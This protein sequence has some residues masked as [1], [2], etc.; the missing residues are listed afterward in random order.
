MNTAP[1]P[2]GEAL[3][4]AILTHPD[5]DTP[6]LAYADHIEEMGY[7][8]RAEFIRAQCRLAAMNPWDEGYTATDV[9]CR[10]LL[11]EHPEWTDAVVRYHP[12]L[13]RQFGS[14]R[15]RGAHGVFVRGFPGVVGATAEWFAHHH[16]SLF[17]RVPVRGVGFH[18]ETAAE[19]DAL[20]GCPG[21]ERLASLGVSMWNEERAGLEML[22]RLRHATGLKRLEVYSERVH[23]EALEA[24]L[25]APQFAA[26]DAFSL[27][28]D[29]YDDEELQP[30]DVLRRLAP[31]SWLFGLRDLHLDGNPFAALCERLAVETPRAP[32]LRRL[33]VRG[34]LGEPGHGVDAAALARVGAGLRS[35]WFA[36]LDDLDLTA[37]AFVGPICEALAASG[38]R[39]PARL[40]FPGR[41][42]GRAGAYSP[43]PDLLRSDWL[44]ELDVL[45]VPRISDVEIAALLASRLP[46]RLR[47]LD[48]SNGTLNGV[49]LRELLDAP[50]GWPLLERLDVSGNS[51]PDT[52]LA[53][54]V[55]RLDRFPRL[56]SLSVGSYNPLP[57]SLRALAAAPAAAQ[58][59]ELCVSGPLAEADALARSP[60]LDGL[61]LVRFEEGEEGP[62][63]DR[64]RKRFGPRLTIDDAIPF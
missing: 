6:R 50:G 52:A 16:E 48:L 58:L 13:V 56:V 23:A 44:S 38:A 10:R 12:D 54:F 39:R 5:E 27:W 1:D 64:L 51:I 47:V 35:G 15:T 40:T 18:L 63:R 7:S 60:H 26:L 30:E 62:G 22:A 55:A 9:R 29:S 28:S 53:E 61:D 8:A 20:A 32:C 49:R 14:L 43:K 24:I 31:S 36:A 34:Y 2:T 4:R 21:L 25:H 57:K 19:R 33:A 45:F 3:Y 46:A 59:R 42:R 17:A 37:C 11:A 41:F